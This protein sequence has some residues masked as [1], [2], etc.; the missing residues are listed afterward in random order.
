MAALTLPDLDL[1]P[2]SDSGCSSLH[3]LSERLS[4]QERDVPSKRVMVAEG[5]KRDLTFTNPK[6]KSTASIIPRNEKKIHP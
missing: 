3:R 1:S 2:G 6:F 4:I 5:K